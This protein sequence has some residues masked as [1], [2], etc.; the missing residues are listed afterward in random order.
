MATRRDTRKF[1]LMQQ[2]THVTLLLHDFP[3][4]GDVATSAGEG[5]F[6]R[7]LSVRCLRA[8]LAAQ[9]LHLTDSAAG[10]CACRPGATQTARCNA[11][12]ATGGDAACTA[13]YVSRRGLRPNATVGSTSGITTHTGA[14][15]DAPH[16]RPIRGTRI[17]QASECVWHAGAQAFHRGRRQGDCHG[18]DRARA[19]VQ[20]ERPGHGVE[21]T[22]APAPGASGAHAEHSGR[23]QHGWC[24][25]EGVC[26]AMHRSERVN[27]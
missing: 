22:L 13:V 9:S 26:L 19:H 27:K 15:R 25:L 18:E 23:L 5:P 10:W 20:P 4:S 7:T 2:H 14:C 1:K 16:T 11:D 12:A 8:H 17:R 24:A 3:Q 6:K 21:R